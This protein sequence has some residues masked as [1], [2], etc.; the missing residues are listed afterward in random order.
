M[1]VVKLGYCN[2]FHCIGPEC[3][4]HCCK[5]W[6][7][8][9]GKREYLDYKKA[10]CGKELKDVIENAFERVRNHEKS[11]LIYNENA[12]Y[13]EIKL[14]ENGECPF[15][16]S[17]GLCMVQKELGEK[18][19][20]HTCTV[21]PRLYGL[22]GGDVLIFGCSLTCPH[23]AELMI[24][25][26]EGLQ[27]VEEE[28]AEGSAPRVSK[29][30]YGIKATPSGW[31][32][33]SQ[34]WTIKSAQ[35]DILQNRSFTIPERLII[36]GFFGKKADEYIE[37]G[38]TEKIGSLYNMMLD[39]EF[40]RSIADSLNTARSDKTTA[41]KSVNG[42]MKMYQAV[43]NTAAPDRLTRLFDKAAE[44]IS[45]VFQDV[46]GDNGKVRITFDTARYFK[47]LG[48]F[49]GIE[50]ERPYILE[51]ILVNQAFLTPP[52]SGL[53]KCF[54]SLAV[55]YNI[56]KISLPAFLEDTRDDRELA[57]AVTRSAKMVINT[58]MAEKVSEKDFEE[59]GAFD[60][61]HAVFLI[62]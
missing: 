16:G 12:N 62:S 13:A 59:H 24:S 61:P 5:E 41:S 45:M 54:F 22:V 9:F 51:N 11:G 37:A 39:N 49:R 57:L 10:D 40:C 47:N 42:F 28:Y 50:S 6:R 34:Y 21:F 55:F 19:L 23:V 58:G 33:F 32:G 25:H 60:L 4:D 43:K 27:V 38:Q 44:S 8:L 30:L 46:E 29:G 53:F 31:K 52:D 26:P 36:L 2:E 15:H 1:K 7:I 20:S 3:T 14:K 35:I 18:A 48:V 56:L 17:D